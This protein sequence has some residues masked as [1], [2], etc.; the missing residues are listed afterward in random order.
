MIDYYLRTADAE[1]MHEA[2]SA[3]GEDVTIDHIGTMYRVLEDGDTVEALPGYHA[4]VRSPEV[5][6]WPD[7]VEL[8]ELETPWR[9]FAG[10]EAD[11]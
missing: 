9:V 6:T 3:L 2:L 10:S 4:N 7:G 11:Q 1:A 5:I 8:L